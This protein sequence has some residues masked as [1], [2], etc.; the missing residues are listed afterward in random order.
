MAVCEWLHMLGPVVM[1]FLNLCQTGQ[2]DG[3]VRLGIMFKNNDF[4]GH[5]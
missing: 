1:V 3:C 4:H 2:L 5:R